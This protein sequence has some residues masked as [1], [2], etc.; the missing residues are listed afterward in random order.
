MKLAKEFLT[1]LHTDESLR[2]FTKSTNMTRGLKYSFDEA[3]LSTLTSYARDLVAIKQSE[4]A[5]T[6]YPSCG[7]DFFVNNSQTFDVTNWVWNTKT[8][9]SDPIIKFIDDMRIFRAYHRKRILRIV[10]VS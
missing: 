10:S 1:Y 4:H 7:L 9:T 5:K 6:V 3:D 8:L 2:A